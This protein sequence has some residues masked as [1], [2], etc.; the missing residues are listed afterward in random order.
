MPEVSI[1]VRTVTIKQLAEKMDEV[2]KNEEESIKE[3]EKLSDEH[4]EAIQ[5]V[6]GEMLI[7]LTKDYAW[8][9]YAIEFD[10]VDRTCID[11]NFSL[12]MNDVLETAHKLETERLLTLKELQEGTEG[13]REELNG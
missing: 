13:L 4:R 2:N 3:W 9:P 6:V 8:L 1:S 10:P 5:N 12:L 7:D 11:I